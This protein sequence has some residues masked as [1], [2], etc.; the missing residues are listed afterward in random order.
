MFQVEH[1]KSKTRAKSW[2]KIHLKMKQ[3]SVMFKKRLYLKKQTQETI[4][5]TQ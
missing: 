1:S 5:Q 2:L 4:L 3:E